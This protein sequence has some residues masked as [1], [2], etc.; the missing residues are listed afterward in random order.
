MTKSRAPRFRRRLSAAAR[1][2]T[3]PPPRAGERGKTP[4]LVARL[5]LPPISRSTSRPRGDHTKPLFPHVMD[6]S[7]NGRREII[8]ERGRS[9]EQALR[10]LAAVVEQR[11]GLLLRLD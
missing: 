2:C 11:P 10:H 6:G 8:D 1:P 9:V 5:D 4:L 3:G 7:T